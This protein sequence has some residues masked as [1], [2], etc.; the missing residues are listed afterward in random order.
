MTEAEV[1]RLSG[2]VGVILA[3]GK[4]TRMLPFTKRWPKPVLPILGKPLIR[5]QVEMMRSL[6][7]EKVFVVIGHLGH[8]VVRALGDGVDGVAVEYVEQTETLGI[9][10]ALAQLEGRLHGPFLLCL[11][12]VYVV[13]SR[14]AEMMDLYAAGARAVLASKVEP[15][16]E[17]IRR[18]FVIVADADG[19]VRRVIEKPRA[20]YGRLKGCGLYLFGVEVFD[21]IRRTPRSAM[22]D[23]YEVTDSIQIMID[24]GHRV[25]HAPV[26]D[27]DL[28]L[29]VPGD[30]LAINA[31]ELR[32]R[33]LQN[34]FFEPPARGEWSR[35]TG[36]VGGAGVT[37]GHGTTLVRCVLFDGCDVP[38]GT[39]LTDAIVTPG[40]VI[41]CRPTTIPPVSP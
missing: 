17:M 28:N 36:V 34:F 13:S 41:Q 31:S 38:D 11:G 19:R 29:T 8:E 21:A 20:D 26:I 32:R 5:H 7:I 37:L 9:A 25:V 23:E 16:P 18:N 35:Y 6:G 1:A 30:L 10:H 3:A 33:G 40:E 15:D 22:R 4:G 12:D 27:D 39:E 14:L 2:F 24:D